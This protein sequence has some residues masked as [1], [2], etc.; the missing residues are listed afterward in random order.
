MF[1]AGLPMPTLRFRVSA[2]LCTDRAL[3][4]CGTRFCSQLSFQ[5][6]RD[7]ERTGCRH[8]EEPPSPE[9]SLNREAAHNLALI[10][11]GSG[12]DELAR[13]VLREHFTV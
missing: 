3:P 12:A 10:Y 4:S 5:A 6:M 9:L 13:Q 8:R 11:R 1:C 2:H 7:L